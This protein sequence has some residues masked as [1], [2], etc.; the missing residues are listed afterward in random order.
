MSI[1]LRRRE[2][3]ATLGGA[4]AWPLEV[5]AQPDDRVR[6]LQMRVLRLQVEAAADKIADFIIGIESQIGLTTQLPWSAAAIDQRRFD[7]L[8]VLRQ[9]PAITELAHLDAS[10]KEQLRVSRLVMDVASS[11]TD[12]SQNPKFTEAV[13]KKVYYGPVYFL[14]PAPPRSAPCEVADSD[15]GKRDVLSGLG[16]YLAL[17]DEQIK[18]VALM[19][20]MPAAKA[21]IMAGDIIVALDDEPLRGLTLNQAVERIRGP[22][23]TPIKLTLIRIGH[24]MP[25][26][27]SITRDVIRENQRVNRCPPVSQAESAG[28]APHMTISLAGPRREAGVSVAEINLKVVQDVVSK[29]EVGEH[30][31]AYVVDS[32]NRVIAHRNPGLVNADFSRL[33][34]VQAARAGLGAASAGFVQDV[35]G[36]EVLAASIAIARLGWLVFAELPAEDA[37]VLA[38]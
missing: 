31:V 1:C 11:E 10:G 26:E 7:D 12:Y 35:N 36:R 37:N 14:R 34:Q 30:G 32:Q 21:G 2:F 4:A 15:V 6:A 19:D 3:F 24:D 23:N 20:N 16:I 33:A 18:V 29:M 13:A 27:F 28:P 8:R 38:R 17:V 5:L 22:E 9:V 25:I